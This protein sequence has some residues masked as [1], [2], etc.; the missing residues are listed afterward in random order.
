MSP[1]QKC[2]QIINA[3]GNYA[4]GCRRNDTVIVKPKELCDHSKISRHLKRKKIALENSFLSLK[5]VGILIMG[6]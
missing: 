5:N 4:P 3:Q 2:T 1:T 6:T